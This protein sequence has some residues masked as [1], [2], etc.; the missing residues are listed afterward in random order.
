MDFDFRAYNARVDEA[1]SF[2]PGTRE[3]AERVKREGEEA[4]NGTPVSSVFRGI[5]YSK[6]CEECSGTG[7][8]ETGW[9]FTSCKPCPACDG[10]GTRWV[11][12]L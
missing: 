4:K 9:L 2:R 6:P 7:E 3:F 1:Q 11:S 10:K 5:G 8:I 12:L